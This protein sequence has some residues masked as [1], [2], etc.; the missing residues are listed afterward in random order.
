[1]V[2]CTLGQRR[3]ASNDPPIDVHFSQDY[4]GFAVDDPSHNI[5][6]SRIGRT[7]PEVLFRSQEWNGL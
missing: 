2:V 5:A 3:F 4:V 6:L 1:M 7:N